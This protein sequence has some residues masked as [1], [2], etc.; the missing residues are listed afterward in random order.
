MARS[1]ITFTVDSVIAWRLEEVARE[2]GLKVSQVLERILAREFGMEHL[3]SDRKGDSS[4]E[5]SRS[6]SK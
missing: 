1:A 3:L 2:R 5:R 4:N 6:G